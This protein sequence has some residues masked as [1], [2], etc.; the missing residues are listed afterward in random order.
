MYARCHMCSKE[1]E[2]RFAQREKK[3]YSL[4]LSDM[5]IL[6]WYADYGMRGRN[7][8]EMSKDVKIQ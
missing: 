2:L 7:Y 5:E 1:S 3:H 8:R 4:F 6:T